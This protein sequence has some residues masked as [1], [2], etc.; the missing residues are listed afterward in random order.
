MIPTLFKLEELMARIRKSD[1]GEV[2]GGEILGC[3]AYADDDVL[4]AESRKDIKGMLHI[5]DI[6]RKERDLK[7][8]KRMKEGI[9]GCKEI[10]DKYVCIPRK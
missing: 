3:L 6:F 8:N 1:K 10:E 7:F 2:I 9:N 5:T 4:M